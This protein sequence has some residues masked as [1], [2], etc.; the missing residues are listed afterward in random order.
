M[1]GN[2]MPRIEPDLEAMNTEQFLAWMLNNCAMDEQEKKVIRH[3]VQGF[4][5]YRLVHE[6]FDSDA[7]EE[8]YPNLSA[9][10]DEESWIA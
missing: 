8:Q 2:N 1:T 3:E 4:L 9:W 5:C 7:V 6:C 10:V